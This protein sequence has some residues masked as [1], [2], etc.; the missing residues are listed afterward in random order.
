MFLIVFRFAL[1]DFGLAQGTPETKVELLKVIPS[2][3]QQR[4][5]AYN[6]PPL[7]V[8]SQVTSPTSRQLVH[9]STTKTANKRLSSI[10][11]TQI[12]QGHKRKVLVS[13]LFPPHN[14]AGWICLI[15][16]FIQQGEIEYQNNISF[17][18]RV[19]VFVW[20]IEGISISD[21]IQNWILLQF[22]YNI[23]Y[24]SVVH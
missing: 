13:F 8:G 10:S 15:S 16:N 11:Q 17:C 20:N 9:Q 19:F 6:R 23:L 22:L 1:V 4:S 21:I 2:E 5:S 3:T 12:K 18:F 7:T 24:E 14:F